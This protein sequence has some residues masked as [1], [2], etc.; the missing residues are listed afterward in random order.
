MGGP[1]TTRL[2]IVE[3]A[4]RAAKEGHGIRSAASA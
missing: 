1:P 3:G 4:E 2:S